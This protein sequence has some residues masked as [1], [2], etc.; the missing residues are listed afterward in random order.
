MIAA[1]Q[2]EVRVQESGDWSTETGRLIGFTKQ[3]EKKSIFQNL[4]ES[5]ASKQAANGLLVADAEGKIEWVNDTFVSITGYQPEELIGPKPGDTLQGKGTHPDTVAQMAEHILRKEF[6]HV[7][8]INYQKGGKPYWVDIRC[9]PL[10]DEEGTLESYFASQ[11]DLTEQ[12]QTEVEKRKGDVIRQTTSE[13][14]RIG[15]WSLD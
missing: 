12:H 13:Q 3:L 2:S 1:D 6:F 4:V 15:G 10:I 5:A 8:V 9:S 14:A 7:Q 11:Q